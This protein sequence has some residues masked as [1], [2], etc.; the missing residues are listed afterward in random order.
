V[1]VY[2]IFSFRKLLRLKR[3]LTCRACEQ[4]CQAAEGTSTE[5]KTAEKGQEGDKAADDKG[6]E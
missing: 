6:D 2:K 3:G 1:Y 5:E 4:T